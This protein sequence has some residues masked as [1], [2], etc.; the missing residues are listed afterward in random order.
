MTQEFSISYNT[1]K[2]LTVSL[3]H[4]L[5]I[6]SHSLLQTDSFALL[7]LRMGT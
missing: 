7:V 2:D 5:G 4:Y 6:Y 1:Q 3:F